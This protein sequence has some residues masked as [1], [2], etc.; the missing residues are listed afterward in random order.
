VHMVVNMESSGSIKDRIP[1]N[2]S[3]SQE[4]VA[5]HVHTRVN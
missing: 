3:S 2:Q 4:T 5:F 1:E